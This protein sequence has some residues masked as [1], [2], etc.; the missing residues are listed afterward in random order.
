MLK[1]F[2]LLCYYLIVSKLNSRIPYVNILRQKLCKKIFDRMGKG[3]NIESNVYFGKGDGLKIGDHSGLGRDIWVQN[4]I[5]E[6]GNDVMIGQDV[7][8]LGGGHHFSNIN[9][10][11]R[12]Q[13]NK[14][15][16]HLSIGND[17]WIGG[18][19]TILGNV[20]RIGNGVIIGA[21]SVVTKPIPDY[22][23]VAGNPAK[24][25]RYR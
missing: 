24:I 16:T 9:I 1:N 17:V 8:I 18:R 22:A 14:E 5:L 25:I 10:P 21:G 15:K 19:V 12:L 23:I 20:E 13:G 2:Y 4:T 3:V 6:V 7:L 11:M